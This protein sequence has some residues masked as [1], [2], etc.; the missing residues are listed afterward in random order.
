MEEDWRRGSCRWA[1]AVLN[2][3]TGIED[4]KDN[5]G[6]LPLLGSFPG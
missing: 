2:L 1:A 3:E 6:H 4:K 5:K